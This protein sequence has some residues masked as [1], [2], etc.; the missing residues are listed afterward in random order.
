MREVT[1]TRKQNPWADRDKLFHDIITSAN[2]YDYRLR[3]LGVVGGR[4]LGFFIDLRHRLY[5][6]LALRTVCV[7]VR[8]CDQ[9]NT[10]ES[11]LQSTE[12]LGRSRKD[13]QFLPETITLKTY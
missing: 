11:T 9:P 6:T 1:Q 13:T 8:V 4:I 5:K 3:G 7:Y 10:H 2:F 12:Q